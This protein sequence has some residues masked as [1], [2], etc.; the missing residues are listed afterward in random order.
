MGGG[1]CCGWTWGGGGECSGSWSPSCAHCEVTA[2][3]SMTASPGSPVKMTRK[4][5]PRTATTGESGLA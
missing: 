1:L 3:S 4:Q 2:R 5:P